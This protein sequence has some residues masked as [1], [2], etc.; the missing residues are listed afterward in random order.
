MGNGGVAK[1][2]PTS[3]SREKGKTR[4]GAEGRRKEGRPSRGDARRGPWSTE[5]G[6]YLE[7]IKQ[8]SRE[9]FFVSAREGFPAP[10]FQRW[11]H[12]H[13]RLSPRGQKFGET[14]PALRAVPT[15]KSG[16]GVSAPPQ[17][18]L[19][20]LHKSPPLPFNLFLQILSSYRTDRPLFPK[21]LGR[22]WPPWEGERQRAQ[23]PQA[24]R[25]PF[26]SDHNPPGRPG[27]GAA[28]RA[29][30]R[31]S[32]PSRAIHNSTTI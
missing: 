3:P 20:T 4:T 32:Q 28:S 21:K 11:V 14:E 24:R 31:P 15:L 2:Q 30:L 29:R 5:G 22:P 9:A 19:R 18:H 6:Q 1:C 12:H 25:A 26:G 27:S 10:Q 17:P 23:K 13:A 7:K 8:K 16:G